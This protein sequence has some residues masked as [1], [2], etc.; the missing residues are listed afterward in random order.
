MLY[1]HI[2]VKQLIFII[3][4]DKIDVTIIAT[5]IEEVKRDYASK[6]LDF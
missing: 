1:M 6:I 5:K 3:Y 2:Y 4:A